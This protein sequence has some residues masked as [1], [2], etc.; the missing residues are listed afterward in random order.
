MNRGGFFFFRLPVHLFVV[1]EERD[2][3]GEGEKCV[4]SFMQ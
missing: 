3:E 2:R 1:V 4:L